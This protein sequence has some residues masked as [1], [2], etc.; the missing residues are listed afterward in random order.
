MQIKQ[1][2]Q[3]IPN[4]GKIFF[5]DIGLNDNGKCRFFPVG[6][7]LVPNVNIG[8][9]LQIKGIISLN[10][11]T[12]TKSY[13]NSTS[14]LAFSNTP[15]TEETPN[16][17][18][19]MVGVASA[20]NMAG[21]AINSGVVYRQKTNTFNFIMDNTIASSFYVIHYVSVRSTLAKVDDYVKFSGFGKDGNLYEGYYEL[22]VLHFKV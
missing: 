2:K 15:I 1:Y 14:Y 7:L 12:F 11:E 4:F 19:R 5:P 17:L 18:G 9:L 6:C 3:T 20:E 22:D 8:D 16:F 10:A 21:R 13:L